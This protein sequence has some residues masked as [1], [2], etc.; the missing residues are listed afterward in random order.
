MKNKYMAPVF[1][2]VALLGTAVHSEAATADNNNLWLNYV[3]DHPLF[4]SPWGVHLEVQ[5]RLSDWGADWQ[6]L[7]VRPGINYQIDPHWSVSAGYA[8]V[9]TDPYG[10][11]PVAHSFDENRIWEQVQYKGDW[12]GIGWTHRVRFEQRW[13]EELRQRTDGDFETANWRGEQRARYLLRSDIPLTKDK[14]TY[15]ALWDEVFFNFGGN[16]LGNHFD[17]NRAFAGIGRK[18]TDH[19]KLEVGYMEQSLHRRGGENWENNHTVCVW[20][21][22]NLPFFPGQSR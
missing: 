10:E 12:L 21:M 8:Y 19:V 13:I 15:F 11:L 14:K 1:A 7:L 5:N 4:S 16:I 20:L 9:R 2:G 18:L 6:Q 17:Q 3:G 22:S